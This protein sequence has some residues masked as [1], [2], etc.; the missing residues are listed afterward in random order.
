MWMSF[1]TSETLNFVYYIHA[2]AVQNLLKPIKISSFC[3]TSKCRNKST[4]CFVSKLAFL[5]IYIFLK[6]D[7][8]RVNKQ[9]RP[10]PLSE[11]ISRYSTCPANQEPHHILSEAFLWECLHKFTILPQYGCITICSIVRSI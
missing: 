7:L 8:N 2:M 6:V 4:K 10:L 5:S 1:I 11:V 3:P 9:G